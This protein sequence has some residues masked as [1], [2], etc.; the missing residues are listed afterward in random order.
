MYD[1]YHFQA[2]EQPFS[3]RASREELRRWE[4]QGLGPFDI[5]DHDLARHLE[6]AH[7]AASMD[8]LSCRDVA[9]VMVRQ[10]IEVSQ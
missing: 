5:E 1:L 2:H 7:R 3:A 6:T 4:D 9:Q 10:S 8:G